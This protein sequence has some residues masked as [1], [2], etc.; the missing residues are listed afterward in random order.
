MKGRF[1]RKYL[2]DYGTKKESIEA[3]S[4]VPMLSCTYSVR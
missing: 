1:V 2:P 4:W 3:L